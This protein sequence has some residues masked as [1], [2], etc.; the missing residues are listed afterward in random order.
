MLIVREVD[1]TADSVFRRF[2]PD[3]DGCVSVADVKDVG[4]VT[5][6][7]EHDGPPEGEDDEDEGVSSSGNDSCISLRAGDKK[8]N[9]LLP[10]LTVVVAP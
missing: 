10:R 2:V 5:A 1:G 8:S 3:V 9:A 6:D 7:A 4:S